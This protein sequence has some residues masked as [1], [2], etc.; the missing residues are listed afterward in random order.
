MKILNLHLP[1]LIK[2]FNLA[3][4][5]IIR[6]ESSRQDVKK[7][8]AAV[9]LSEWSGSNKFLWVNSSDTDQTID[10]K[11]STSNQESSELL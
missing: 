9:G 7:I 8:S 1:Q 3:L 6:N 11:L 5:K 4:L 2:R 10:G